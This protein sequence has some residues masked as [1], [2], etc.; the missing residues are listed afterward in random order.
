MVMVRK[1]DTRGFN[2]WVAQRVSAVLIA[3]YT[4]YLLCFIICH[5]GL[6]FASWTHLFECAW[7]RV[8]TV[9]VLL[10]LLWHAWIGLWTVFTDYV[11]CHG[12]RLTLQV[13]LIILLTGYLVWCL[14]TLWG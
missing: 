11:K 13:G 2:E 8:A 12:L 4:I 10:S 14:N 3:I 7:M 9:L 1:V 5:P 6:D